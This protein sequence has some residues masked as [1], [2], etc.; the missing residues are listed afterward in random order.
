[1]EIWK[2]IIGFEGIYQVSNLGNIKSLNY[3]NTNKEKLLKIQIDKYGYK[4]I[5]LREKHQKNK[6]KKVHRLVA[7]AFIEN[8]YNFTEINHK[9]ENKLNN[10]VE[11]LEWCTKQYNHDYGTR[12]ERVGIK[13]R[14]KIICIT[15]NEIYNSIKE[16]GEKYNLCRGDISRC[17]QNKRTYCGKHPITKKKLVWRY[18]Q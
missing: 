9:D 14:K 4:V 11:N 13:N 7:E 8:P 18:Y 3:L 2:D 17:C 12:N 15:T 6:I 10:R 16:A 5:S 1:M